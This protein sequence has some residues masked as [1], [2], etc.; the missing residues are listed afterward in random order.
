M[1]FINSNRRKRAIKSQKLDGMATYSGLKYDL[2]A[3]TRLCQRL[4]WER[5]WIVW[6]VIVVQEAELIYGRDRRL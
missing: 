2:K 3:V 1:K 5:L 6:E 4:Y